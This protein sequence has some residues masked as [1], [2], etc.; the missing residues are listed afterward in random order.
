[1]ALI[2]ID[3]GEKGAGGQIL[4]AALALSGATG[5]GFEL[6][7]IRADR[8]R[9]GLK[10]HHVDTIRAAALVCGAR[11]GGAFDGSPDLR[12][13]PGAV[14]PGKYGF[15]VGGGGPVSLVIETV[16]PILAA[17][18][19]AS[20]VEA[21]G[22]THVPASPSADYLARPF[23]AT[24]ERL[25]LGLEVDVERVGFRARGGGE[26]RALVR[27]TPRAESPRLDE[28]GSLVGLRGLSGAGRMKEPV[29][30]RMRDAALALLWRARRLEA[31]WDVLEV[32]SAS[33][34]A[35][36]MVE[37]V[38]EHGRGAFAY[39]LDRSVKPEV[40]AERAA[41]RVL[42]FVEEEDGALDPWLAD[43]IAVPLALAGGG[44]LTTTEVTRHL[45]TVA[46]VSTRFGRPAR[47]WGRH[48]GP[49]GLEIDRC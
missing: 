26:V 47:V 40:L 8:P 13:E 25:G 10:P 46:S 20:T 35:F 29:A 16:A 5:Q 45:E 9:P 33:P 19:E 4:R 34:G 15:E 2:T 31:A 49:G 41:R 7:R 6:V 43:Q 3:G 18:S 39:L 27:R 14:A 24:A 22:G 37:A 11:T 21:S 38:F 28:R 12:F 44:R 30:L 17:A 32:K 36:L 42:K 1:V 23:A 48:G